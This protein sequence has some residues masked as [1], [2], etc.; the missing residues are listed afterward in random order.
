MS[1]FKY[2]NLLDIQKTLQAAQHKAVISACGRMIGPCGCCVI[3][4]AE[5]RIMHIPTLRFGEKP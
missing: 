5:G 1:G 4:R 2:V 3:D